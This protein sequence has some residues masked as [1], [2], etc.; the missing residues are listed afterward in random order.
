MKA[1]RFA[2][3]ASLLAALPAAAADRTSVGRFAPGEAFTPPPDHAPPRTSRVFVR[4]VEV[5]DGRA[6]VEVPVSG[7]ERLLIWT[8]AAGAPVASALR[9]PGGRAL[10]PQET[11][12]ADGSVRR[13]PLDV[14]DLGLDLPGALEALEVRNAEAGPYVIELEASGA[15]GVSVV[16]AEPGS[17]LALSSWAGPLS[18]R[19]DEPVVLGATLRD[20][21]EPVTAR[22]T[23]R[24][25]GPDGMAGKPIEMFDDGLHQ[26]GAAGDGRYG[27]SIEGAARAAG[28]WSVRFDASGSDA[29]G[30]AFERTSSSGFMTESGAASLDATRAT[31]GRGLSVAAVADVK[32]AGR[33]RLDVLVATTPDADGR[34][35]GVA[36]ARTPQTLAVGRTP[37]AVTIDADSLGEAA[38]GP[39]FVDV[40]LVGE[41]APGVSRTTLTVPRAR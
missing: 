13:V 32:V 41:D 15:A 27:M 26:D 9:A 28:F 10:S 34:Q 38:A 25:A 37:L 35:A 19:P 22:V 40:R 31:L 1:I 23:A 12:S 29:R 2:L 8:V 39:L 6:V 24:L 33:Y 17:P 30:G 5:R 16:V 36:W 14:A 7:S 11:R 3:A 21:R 18:H 4:A 20:G